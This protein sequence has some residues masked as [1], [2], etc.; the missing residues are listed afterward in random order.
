MISVCIATY[1]GGR[2]I[3]EQLESIISQLSE[4][5]ELII[6]D[7][8]STDN[9]VDIISSFN[10]N[11]II[12]LY[13]NNK[14]GFVGNF[15]NALK[16]SKGDYV[17]LSDQDDIWKPNK[18]K[19]VKEQLRQYALIVH[20]AELVDGEG[21]P[22][23]KNY[24]STLHGK[25]SFLANLWKTRWLGCCMAFRREVLEACLPFPNGII[26][27]D[28]WIGMYGMIKFDYCFMKD[29]LIS[30]R[31]HNN[32]VSTSSEKSNN[33]IWFKLVKKRLNIIMS[34]TRR[35]VSR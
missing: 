5:D 4:N 29:A 8:G 24:F 21:K 22:L 18:V 32:N 7:D 14:H 13:N 2:F 12:L 33:S 30:Y 17:F 11:R 23:G 16:M 10:D 35:L 6:S 25:E 15:E 31:R 9:T 3:K 28:Y 27:H 19:V 20:D 1:N 26:A 34:I